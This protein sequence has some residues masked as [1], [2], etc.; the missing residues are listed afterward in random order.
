M[1]RIYFIIS[2][3][4]F[5]NTIPQNEKEINLLKEELE[6]NMI[7]KQKLEKCL[8]YYF[9][10]NKKEKQENNNSLKYKVEFKSKL[11][12]NLKW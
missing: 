11:E 5:N 8:E 4:S 1:G 7:E 12:K 9:A 6:K 3:V 10:L 2:S